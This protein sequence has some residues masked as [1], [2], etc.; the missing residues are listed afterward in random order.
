VEVD[1]ARNEA[2]LRSVEPTRRGDDAF[3]SELLLRGTR[4]A[5]LRRY[6]AARPDARREQVAFALT[7]EALA[8]VVGDLT[9]EA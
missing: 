7:H 6:R 8:K 2:L 1:A 3:Y 4:A 9:A 5:E